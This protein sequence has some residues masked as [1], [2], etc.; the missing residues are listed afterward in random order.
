MYMH[1]LLWVWHDDTTS[2]PIHGRLN[3]ALTY[4][5]LYLFTTLGWALSQRRDNSSGSL[6]WEKY[7]AYLLEIFVSSNMYCNI[8]SSGNIYCNISSSGNIYCN[9][10][11]HCNSYCIQYIAI[12]CTNIIDLE[13]IWCDWNKVRWWIVLQYILQLFQV[14]PIYIA[15]FWS[16]AIYIAIVQYI[17]MCI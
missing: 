8:W 5:K 15:I 17:A 3:T 9:I 4:A 10:P 7:I 1:R 16:W 11:I 2:C 13:L 6:P 12:Y 14:C